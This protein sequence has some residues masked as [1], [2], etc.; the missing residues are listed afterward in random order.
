MHFEPYLYLADVTSTRALVAW[1]G[2]FFQRDDD[3]ALSI[4]DDEA[5]P[6]HA[7]G[8]T[9]TIGALSEPYG[10]ARVDVFDV[11]GQRVASAETRERNHVWIDGLVANTEYVYRVLVDE[12]PWAV[13]ELFD[14]D[15]R[16][17]KLVPRG[18]RY[19]KRFR[20]HPAPDQDVALSFGVLGDYGVGIRGASPAATRQH[21]LALALERALEERDLRLLVTTGDNI[22]HID[23]HA[24]TQGSGD[25]DDDWFFTFYQPYRYLISRIPVYP[26]VGNH[27]SED[28]ENSD[29]RL[30]LLDNFFIDERFGQ[31]H[32]AARGSGLFYR[33]RIGANLELVCIDTSNVGGRPDHH[34]FTEPQNQAFLERAFASL[35]GV[36]PWKVPFSHHPAFCAGPSHPNHEGMLRRLVPLFEQ[37][38]VRLVLA[39]HEHNF[40]YSRQNDVHYFITGA[41]GKL[42]ERAPERLEEAHVV[43]WAAKGHVL[44]VDVSRDELVVHPIGE[45]DDGSFRELEA[46]RPDGSTVAGP[47][48]IRAA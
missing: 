31:M 29:D 44:I 37:A 28:S 33:A 30:Q 23:H 47:F 15:R 26:S 11:R 20:T 34:C 38:G 25:E 45:T 46:S 41:A 24:K 12:K 4:V 1:G 43:A 6:K 14:W 22:Y 18:R 35:G 32:D 40:Q 7:P 48:V 27:D 9:D 39:G 42:R 17:D 2:F 19:D 16:L 8:R 3:G 10:R 13:G 36:V 21:R 5:L